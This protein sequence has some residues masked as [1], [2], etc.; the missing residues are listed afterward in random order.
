VGARPGAG[1]LLL[2][3]STARLSGAGC[4]GNSTDCSSGNCGPP[5][6]G[7]CSLAS[8]MAPKSNA[9]KYSLRAARMDRHASSSR[10]VAAAGTA[11]HGRSTESAAAARKQDTGP[12]STSN[13][14]SQNVGL[15]T[16]S[17]KA[18]AK[19][20]VGGA[21]AV[22]DSASRPGTTTGVLWHVQH[23]CVGRGVSQ[24]SERGKRISSLPW[25]QWHAPG[26]RLQSRTDACRR[27]EA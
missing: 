4:V 20:S 24:S 16:N 18:S 1:A 27:R 9:R 13:A 19:P 10:P 6:T 7:D 15:S 17:S 26:P 23:A 12:P 21:I 8:L 2:P 11:R 14:R 3:L 5:R 22:G 25:H